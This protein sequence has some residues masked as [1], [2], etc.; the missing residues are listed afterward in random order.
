MIDDIVAGVISAVILY[1]MDITGRWVFCRSCAP[2]PD[3]TLSRLIRPVY[4]FKS[5]DRMRFIGVS[6]SA[7]CSGFKVISTAFSIHQAVPPE[8]FR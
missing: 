2:M 8:K 3:V 4:L 7:I 5:Y 1:F 6:S